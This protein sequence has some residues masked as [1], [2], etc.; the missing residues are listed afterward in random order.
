MTNGINSLR[1]RLQN[2][3]SEL[4]KRNKKL[5]KEK[6][7]KKDFYSEIALE[8]VRH[9]AFRRGLTHNIAT[10][11]LQTDAWVVIHQQEREDGQGRE[12]TRS[13][14]IPSEEQALDRLREHWGDELDPSLIDLM[15]QQV[16]HEPTFEKISIEKATDSIKGYIETLVKHYSDES[17]S[18]GYPE[19]FNS[20]EDFFQHLEAKQSIQLDEIL[21]VLNHPKS[22]GLIKKVGGK[23]RSVL[24]EQQWL[25]E[26]GVEK[27]HNGKPKSTYPLDQIKNVEL[28]AIKQPQVYALIAIEEYLFFSEGAHLLIALANSHSEMYES[29][30]ADKVRPALADDPTIGLWI[31]QE[32][33][34]EEIVKM[35]SMG[36]DFQPI[37]DD[38]KRCVGTIELKQVM[39]H[40]QN[41]EFG[42]LPKTIDRNELASIGLLSPAPPIVDARLPLH[43]VNEIMYYGIG[44]V[45][46]RYDPKHWS[47][48][49]REQLDPHLKPGI[50]IFTKHDYV[51]AK[52]RG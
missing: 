32:N 2:V 41:H 43:R 47:K 25:D 23:K 5:Q 21:S 35:T 24:T 22:M 29:Y 48:E 46:L 38:T 37:F 51:M 39:L 34:H 40:L 13:E 19:S 31:G 52:T 4:V 6:N 36:F 30:G 17:V 33:L 16:V 28:K 15:L 12:F 44:C 7:Q 3:A 20:Q 11:T 9:H 10:G 14:P 26:H 8:V 18:L 45:L 1:T 42:S 27:D 49:E 50:H